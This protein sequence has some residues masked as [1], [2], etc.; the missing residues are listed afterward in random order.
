MGLQIKFKTSY[1]SEGKPGFAYNLI[2]T[3][4]TEEQRVKE[5][6]EYKRVKGEHYKEDAV[7][8][9]PMFFS[10]DFA[11]DNTEIVLNKNKEGKENYYLDNT[12]FLKMT[13]MVNQAGN[14]TF[15]DALAKAFAQK[16]SK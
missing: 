12:E 9:Q 4:E 7:T 15:A 8:K 16:L 13:S 10:N 11:V 2:S 6:A 5:L 3:A 1:K 14:G